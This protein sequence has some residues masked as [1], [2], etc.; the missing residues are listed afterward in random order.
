MGGVCRMG[1]SEFKSGNVNGIRRLEDIPEEETIFKCF[2]KF[3]ERCCRNMQWIALL[4]SSDTGW[5][6]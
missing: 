3:S 5:P 2:L 1:K 4:H 6:L